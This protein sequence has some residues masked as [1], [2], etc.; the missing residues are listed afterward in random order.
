MKKYQPIKK[1][2]NNHFDL[3]KTTLKFDKKIFHIS[4]KLIKTLKKNSCIFWC[5][6]GGSAADA[7]H[8]SAELV[9]RFEKE[10]I[11]LRSI[12]LN[13]DTSALTAIANDYDY[14]KIF[15]RQ[16]EGLSKNGDALV[17]FST[18]GNSKN[19]IDV[20]KTA[21][22]KKILSIGIFGN[23]GGKAKKY[24]DEDIS[25]PI[26]NTARIQ[27]VHILIGHIICYLIEKKIIKKK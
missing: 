2:I 16:L 25:L 27:E 20:L 19:I 9:G 14:K 18:S 13:T 23:N 8:L 12:A 26:S 1:I 15:S 24:C 6:N 17:V 21:K 11:A 3:R 7:Q 5:G 4:E 22:N 10:R